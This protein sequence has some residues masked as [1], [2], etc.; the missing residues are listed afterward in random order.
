MSHPWI[1]FGLIAFAAVL[2]FAIGLFFLEAVTFRS[3]ENKPHVWPDHAQRER[4]RMEALRG[5]DQWPR[6]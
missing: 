3:T 4:E 6:F 1:L 5:D 2:S